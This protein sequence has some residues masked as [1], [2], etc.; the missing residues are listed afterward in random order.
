VR[1]VGVLAM[2]GLMAAAYAIGMAAW[3]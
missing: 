1:I 3:S 2:L